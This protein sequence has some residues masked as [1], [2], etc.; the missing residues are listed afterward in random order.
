MWCRSEGAVNTEARL[1]DS[2]ANFRD[3]HLVGTVQ[4]QGISMEPIIPSGAT[5]HVRGC[6]QPPRVGEVVVFWCRG[7]VIVHRLRKVKEIEG[8][9]CFQ[10]QGDGNVKPDAWVDARMIVGRVENVPKHSLLALRCKS[11]LRRKLMESCRRLRKILG[12]RS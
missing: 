8:H 3:L 7:K 6:D 9:L 5:I 12:R 2:L 10:A 11:F 1:P 4:M